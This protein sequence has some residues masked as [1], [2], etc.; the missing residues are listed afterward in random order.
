MPAA[1]SRAGLKRSPSTAVNGVVPP[2]APS[3][4]AGPPPAPALLESPH[5]QPCLHRRLRAERR[6]HLTPD[7]VARPPVRLERRVAP[8]S[9]Q[10][11]PYSRAERGF[12]VR[13]LRHERVAVGVPRAVD[14]RPH[15]RPDG[16]TQLPLE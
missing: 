11:P 16:R 5:P 15:T 12:V 7:A 10:R 1:T 8:T 4:S 14:C 2:P 6:G 3:R 13:L 9:P